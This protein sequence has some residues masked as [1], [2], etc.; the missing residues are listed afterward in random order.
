L[1]NTINGVFKTSQTYTENLL[2]ES[3]VDLNEMVTQM[4]IS[5]IFDTEEDDD[6]IPDVDITDIVCE[7]GSD[8]ERIP[9]DIQGSPELRKQITDLCTEYKDIF[10]A[11]VKS[12]PARVEPLRFDCDTA[13]WLRPGNRLPARPMSIDKQHDLSEILDELLAL[14][15]IRASKATAWSQVVMVKKPTGKWR[16]TIDFRNLNKGI[17]NQGWQIPNMSQMIN[18]IGA[19]KPTVFGSADLTMGYYQMPLHEDCVPLTA[20]ITF[21]GIYEW[22]RVPMGILPAANYFQKTMSE[23][24]LTG[25]MYSMCEDYIDDLLIAATDDLEFMGYLKLI[26]QRL[27][28]KMLP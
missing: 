4:H 27:R 15:V 19:K 12:E 7:V 22:N 17:V 16:L 18:R 11:T 2:K 26:F 28:E 25:F 5:E 9:H 13:M 21:R 10:S 6:E 8:E 20:F 14:G 3:L 1:V 24:V 23:D